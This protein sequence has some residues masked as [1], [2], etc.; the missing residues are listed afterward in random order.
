MLIV[1]VTEPRHSP[2]ELDNR[3][4]PDPSAD[5]AYRL[6]S[7]LHAYDRQDYVTAL[8][9]LRPL[10]EEGDNEALY[11]MGTMYQNGEGVLKDSAVA[12]DWFV[13]ARRWALVDA[14]KGNLADQLR[15]ATMF[16]RGQGG[17]IDLVSAHA[18]FNIA[19]SSRA[20]VT[21]SAADKEVRSNEFDII[22]GNLYRRQTVDLEKEA[23]FRR[24][25]IELL[26]KPAEVAQA[27]A[28]ARQC[29]ASNFGQC[30]TG[31]VSA[32]VANIFRSPSEH[33]QTTASPRAFIPMKRHGGTF[34]VPVVVNGTLTLDFVVDSGASDVSVS[35]DVVATLVRAGTI[36]QSD[37]LETKIYVLADGSQVPSQTFRIRSLKVGDR[38]VENVTGRVASAKSPLLLGQS[39][40]A[41]FK[42]WSVD[43]NKHVLVLQ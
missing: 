14:K 35:E 16:E 40:L 5:H 22:V 15:L 4:L 38:L 19:A 17:A 37:F 13:L 41:R 42:S 27:Q 12:F 34:V 2:A 7:G 11:M 23:R 8:K 28:M 33:S 1:S 39:F 3:A 6:R 29:L 36:V 25:V 24:K 18:W 31:D 43:N 20:E 21:T 10:A 30:G 9:W 26:M 32:G